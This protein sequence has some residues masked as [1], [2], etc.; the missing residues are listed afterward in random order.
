MGWSSKSNEDRERVTELMELYEFAQELNTI[1]FNISTDDLEQEAQE[2]GVSLAL[3]RA[4]L[5]DLC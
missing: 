2:H 3:R 5:E 1:G 4:T